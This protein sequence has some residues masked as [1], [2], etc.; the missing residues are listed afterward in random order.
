MPISNQLI[1]NYEKISRN[2]FTLENDI[3]IINENDII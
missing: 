2:Y 1:V 3:Y